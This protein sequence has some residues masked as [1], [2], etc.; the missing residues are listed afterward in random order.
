M[1]K[2]ITLGGLLLATLSASAQWN[3]D[4]T[5][6]RVTDLQTSRP[7][8]VKTLRLEGGRTLVTWTQQTGSDYMAPRNLFMQLL[9]KDGVRQLGNSGVRVNRYDLYNYST[10]YNLVTDSVG[11]AI[12]AY[13]DCRTDTSNTG[14]FYKP[15]FYKVDPTGQQLW[16]K[17]GVAADVAD[18]MRCGD[19]DLVNCN[20][21]IYALFTRPRTATSVY[22]DV[23]V[24]EKL[25]ADGTDAFSEPVVIDGTGAS[26]FPTSDGFIAVYL[27][28]E[29]PYAQRY[30]GTT[31]QPVWQDPLPLYPSTSM[32]GGWNEK[33]FLG[34]PDGNDG[35]II[36]YEASDENY[37]T[38]NVFQ[39]I[40]GSR[41]AE[42][43]VDYLNGYTSDASTKLLFNPEEKAIY[44][45]YNQRSS[46][47][48]SNS[49]KL[50]KFGYDLKSQWSEAKTLGTASIAPTGYKLLKGDDGGVVAVYGIQPSYDTTFV[51]LAHYA[52]NGDSL[53]TSRAH[54]SASIA[55]VNCENDQNGI[56]TFFTEAPTSSSVGV[57]GLMVNN[58]GTV[59]L[60]YDL[61]INVA[62]P[63]T[64]A[65]LVPE[66]KKYTAT[67]LK[68]SGQ[69]N[70]DDVVVLRDMCGVSSDQ[71]A[72]E[73]KVTRLN[74]ADA[75]FVT[76]GSSY[77]SVPDEYGWEDV[78]LYTN[79]DEVPANL[80]SAGEQG[81]E[82]T[83]VILPRTAK[84]IGSSALANN[85]SLTQITIPD[86]VSSIE[87]NAFAG[88]GLT[89][90]V[91][92]ASVSYIGK[93]AFF[94]CANMTSA[95][96]PESTTRLPEG[97]FSQTALEQ[98]HIPD[99]V[100]SIG[101]AAFHFCYSLRHLSG[102]SRVNTLGSYALNYCKQL[103]ELRLSDSLEYI[104]GKAL[105]NLFSL[106]EIKIPAKVS[107]IVNSSFYEGPFDG[108]FA[109]E[110]FVV[111][112]ANNSY[113]DIDGV[114]FTKDGSELV[115][116]PMGKALTDSS[117]TVPEGVEKISAYA[118]YGKTDMARLSLPL[119]LASIGNSAFDN[120]VELG[121]IESLNT[122][123]PAF[124][125]MSNFYGVDKDNC[126]LVV[127]D[128]ALEA[129]KAA[130]VWKDFLNATTTG[131]QHATTTAGRRILGV[132]SLDGCSSTLS[133]QG[134][135]V[136]RYSDGTSRKVILK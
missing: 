107:Q 47:W 120:C 114:L 86:S 16:G 20:G 126:L 131:I 89:S 34:Y 54:G 117:Y 60:P 27:S 62:E 99:S 136:I 24:V 4:S 79:D 26:I 135:R 105:S 41:T 56:Y 82:M 115:A 103:E 67:S 3:S 109:L 31:G 134:I 83:T 10:P 78:A 72:T 122:V 43:P 71:Q 1:R 15:Y 13:L 87:D 94:G 49:L 132:Y 42:T 52:A 96:L 46:D 88:S 28:N 45:L 128:G 36:Q 81:C 92:P 133:G 64:L 93:Y 65:G 119:S 75:R 108:D 35:L 113:Q 63:G 39:K 37:N 6:F 101:T 51:Y 22:D 7:E 123:P 38:I 50:Q 8:N 104:G 57:A 76:G 69:L 73:G 95:V 23:S 29:H 124:T 91:V 58:D 68:L 129:Y 12:V 48:S 18:S 55:Y 25:K 30:N 44:A 5:V 59:G 102:G 106:K 11:N 110:R 17:D 77:A 121:R 90:V 98:F 9:D 66:D 127:P 33:T 130:D 32:F 85:A 125:G 61:N 19:L 40:S 118:F 84:S 100:T 2:I 111:D 112:P 97:I 70:G 14:A 74:L 80:F 53:W 116:M 21:D